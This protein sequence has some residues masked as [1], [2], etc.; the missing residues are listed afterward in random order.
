MNQT[1]EK[2]LRENYV[3][4]E[5][6]THVSMVQ[7]KGR[8]SINRAT[9]ET[10]WTLYN[11]EIQNN[12]EIILGLAEKPQN[13]LP[14][15]VDI[16]L[17]FKDPEHERTF[18]YTEE[19]VLKIIEIYHNV[20]K[21]TVEGITDDNLLC[22]YL[23]KE[24]YRLV[25]ND[26]S[27]IKNGFHLHF[28]NLFLSVKD[29]EVHIIPRVQAI[30]TERQI[31]E[32][33]G[34]E[35]SGILLDKASCKVPWLLYGSRKSEDAK[36]YR[37][38]KVFNY[39]LKE[40]D[41]DNAFKN[42]S[43]Y[44][45]REQKI[46]IRGNVP[47]YL[48]QILSILPYG[49]QTKETKQGLISPLKDR[50]I[51]EE[52]KREYQSIA[53]S[54][55]LTIARK[56]I[57]ILAPF[58]SEDRNEWMTVGWVLYNIGEGSSEA[59]DIWNEFSARSSDNYDESVCVFEWERMTKKELTLGT[60][61]Y[62]A[63]VDNP[64]MYAIFKEEQ[65]Q[66][67]VN[68]S[69]NGG[70]HNDIAKVLLEEYGNEFICASIVNKIWYQYKDHIWQANED[71]TYL[72]SKISSEIVKHYEDSAKKSLTGMSSG[73]DD[74]EEASVHQNRLNKTQKIIMNLKS[75][76]FK[77]N[78]MREAMEVFYDRMF[79]NKLDT[80]PYLIAFKNGV[81][82]LKLNIFRNGR[83]EDYIS[84]AMPIEYKDY[85]S[86]DSEV[87]EVFSFLEKVFPD[88]SVR[89]YFMD[90]AS[91]VFVGGNHQKIVLFWTGE[92]D[93]GKSV[94]QSFFDHMLGPLAIKFNTTVVTGKKPS[95]GGTWADLA[96][97]GGGVRWA[98]LEEPGNDETINTGVLKW[99]SGNDTIYA[100]ELFEKGKDVR[101]IV[102]MFKLV[103]IC[104]K[105]PKLS[106][107]DN[108]TW[109]RIRVIP[110][111]STFCRPDDPAPLTYEEQVQQKR[112]PMDRELSQR[113]PH[114]VQSFAWILLQHRLTVTVRIE[115]EK[116]TSATSTYRRQND[117]YRQFVDEFIVHEDRSIL[118]MVELYNNFK[119]WH[120]DS[121]PHYTL[122]IKNEVKEYF[123]KLWGEPTRNR[124]IGYKI[125]LLDDDD[126]II[127]DNN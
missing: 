46:N 64:E 9:L 111:E 37:F 69:L 4:G 66:V 76:P 110:F 38:S 68:N 20:L 78:I 18:L 16:D 107:G 14:I 77:N 55:A 28:P 106:Y 17:K 41:I 32:D 12:P 79:R 23:N 101:E 2:I 104:N 60:L 85:T 126:V 61:N 15:L 31:F 94:T 6:H 33:M 27:Y 95:S 43:I 21:N 109:N 91:D 42:Y 99:L 59:F 73:T 90:M 1:I 24:P 75:S 30:M 57:P 70:S 53:V 11:T 120:K 102:P 116:V 80:N 92:G 3:A 87:H 96:R 124:W 82:D 88:K 36:P 113:I 62:Y 97:A 122:P 119:E 117:V 26:I 114:L 47:Y 39:Q 86:D 5:Y 35:N 67:K 58:R 74:R 125:K 25:K 81:Y 123:I 49:R 50:K 8:Y 121:L 65:I 40:L 44:N 108:A 127:I 63:K 71:G 93:N 84:K 7:P 103:F 83:P 56:L 118:T 72:R 10:F 19:H 89:Q 98:T 45:I 13:Y 54:E 51:I 105:L 29:Q 115:P 48:P 100:R 112:F 52:K 34:F 22:V